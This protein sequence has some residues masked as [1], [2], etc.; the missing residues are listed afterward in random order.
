MEFNSVFKG[1][2]YDKTDYVKEIRNDWFLQSIRKVFTVRYELNYCVNA[3]TK[4]PLEIRCIYVYIYIYIH[5]HIYIYIY[6]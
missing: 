6:I 1:L 3:S 2:N 4:T 5:T